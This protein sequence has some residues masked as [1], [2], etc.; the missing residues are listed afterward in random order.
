MSVLT[1]PP[2]SARSGAP[3]RPGRG[4]AAAGAVAAVLGGLSTGVVSSHLN[5]VYEV[6]PRGAEATVAAMAD[7]R[8][9]VLAHHVT[10]L[11]AALL[12]LVAAAGL[13]RRLAGRLARGSLLPAVAAGGLGLVS[14]AGLMGT[15]LTTELYFGL[16]D[17]SLAVPEALV[18]MGH[19]TGT[20][21][22]LWVGAGVTGLCVALAALRH[23]AAPAWLGVASLLLGGLTLLVGVSPFQYLAGMTGPVWLLVVSLGFWLGDRRAG[24]LEPRPEI[25]A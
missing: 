22:W 1:S 8:A 16:G 7:E 12:L 17:P 4:W 24:R 23:R 5:A 15:G 11:P 21:A 25:P 2:Q 3:A 18:L 19:W 20:V 10:N 9:W 14:V 6:S 13:H